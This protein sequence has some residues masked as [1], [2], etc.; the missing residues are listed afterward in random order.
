MPPE[1]AHNRAITTTYL[2]KSEDL[3]H[4]KTLYGARCVDWCTHAAYIAAQDC[5]DEF[6]PMVFMSVRNLSMRD[7]A[8]LGEIVRLTGRVDYVGECTIGI[9]VDARKLQPKNDPAL[10][11]TGTF[12]FCTVDPSGKAIPHGLPALVPESAAAE[13]RWK[14]MV[15]EEASYHE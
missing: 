3:N 4:H 14:K 1:D 8:R 9:R 6:R 10:V 12:L 11:A 5:F 7:P 15:E 13:S 2:V